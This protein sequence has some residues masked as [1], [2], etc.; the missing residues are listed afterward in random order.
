[1][2]RAA[3]VLG[4]AAR[5]GELAGKSAAEPDWT[6]VAS[7]LAEVSEHWDDAR[8]ADRPE[9]SGATLLRGSGQIV[10]PAEVVV[11]GRG[12]AARKGLVIATGTEPAIPPVDGLSGVPYWTNREAVEAGTIPGR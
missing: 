5:A 1:M 12:F 3:G 9:R 2:A 6:V 10:G 4:E 7:R 8:A 11:G